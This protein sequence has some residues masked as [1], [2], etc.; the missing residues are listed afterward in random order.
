MG[1]PEYFPS[2][3]Y[4]MKWEAALQPTERAWK[5]GK[6]LQYGKQISSLGQNES[7]LSRELVKSWLMLDYR[8]ITGTSS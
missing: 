4:E 2:Q 1:D 7:E 6:V 5:T 3:P 8:A